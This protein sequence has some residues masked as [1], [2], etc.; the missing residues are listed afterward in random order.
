MKKIILFL[1]CCFV[2]FFKVN[3][4]I[5]VPIYDEKLYSPV[6]CDML[7]AIHFETKNK[8]LFEVCKNREIVDE[9]NGFYS[10]SYLKNCPASYPLKNKEKGC[11]V[12]DGLEDVIVVN[13]E[14]CNVCPNREV[15]TEEDEY[16]VEGKE[17]KKYI[18]HCQL[19]QCPE[20]APLRGDGDCLSC[21]EGVWTDDPK[22]ICDKCPNR[23]FIDKGEVVFVGVK[24]GNRWIKKTAHAGCYLKED[25]DGYDEPLF[26]VPLEE[27]VLTP[28]CEEGKNCIIGYITGIARIWCSDI[29]QYYCEHRQRFYP[30]DEKDDIETLPEVCAKCPNR[31]YVE[32]K[33]IFRECPAGSIKKIDDND[34]DLCEECDRN[35]L[36][37]EITTKEECHKCPNRFWGM[38]R[39]EDGKYVCAHCNID[40]G[41]ITTE[42]E[43]TRCPFMKYYPEMKMCVL[44]GLIPQK[45]ETGEIYLERDTEYYRPSIGA[46]AIPLIDLEIPNLPPPLF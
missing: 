8:K 40:D 38:T 36:D 30:C 3:A 35:Q 43:C 10:V 46:E 31:D 25:K 37:I 12:C 45:E 27:E 2:S 19:K 44:K 4:Y 16:Y 24:D 42:E 21:E 20:N 22:E 13:K 5:G 6:N 39:G 9:E 26:S 28:P 34:Y 41:Y 32:G 1:A 15:R 29:P 18:Y 33:C 17:I 14:D 23:Q 11:F 7:D